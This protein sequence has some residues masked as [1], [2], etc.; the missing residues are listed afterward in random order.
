MKYMPEFV[1]LDD[2]LL[3]KMLVEENYYEGE[4]F[5]EYK[6]ILT[7]AEFEY[8]KMKFSDLYSTKEISLLKNKNYSAITSMGNRVKEKLKRYFNNK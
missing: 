2:V 7:D 1:S 3:N 5:E 4:L 6:D 8:I